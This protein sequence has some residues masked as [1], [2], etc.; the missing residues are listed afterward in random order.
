MLKK[1]K[2]WSSW[3]EIMALTALHAFP[4]LYCRSNLLTPETPAAFIAEAYRDELVA[5]LYAMSFWQR[6][7]LVSI[8]PPAMVLMAIAQTAVNGRHIARQRRRS[9]VGQFNDQIRLAFRHGVPAMYYYL[10]ELHDP[11]NSLRAHEYIYRG[12][13]KSGGLY[14]RLYR[15]APERGTRLRS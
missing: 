7:I 11:R 14:R 1:R 6:W 8:W 3:L 13:L 2:T 10:F 4:A 5:K 15:G 12:Y 9:I